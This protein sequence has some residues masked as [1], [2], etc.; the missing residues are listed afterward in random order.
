[1]I[2]VKLAAVA[3]DCG[4]RFHRRA[5]TAVTD[6]AVRGLETDTRR[7][8]EGEVFAAIK[9]E[10][11]DGA[12]LVAQL[13]DV[14]ASA[15]AASSKAPEGDRA[16]YASIA[17]GSRLTAIDASPVLGG[18]ASCGTADPAAA[19]SSAANGD[20][21]R[22]AEAARQWLQTDAAQLAPAQRSRQ[23]ARIE[24]VA[25]LQSSMLAAGAPDGRSGPA[26]PPA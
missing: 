2:P 20:S 13:Q 6:E 16:S 24:S 15:L 19:G 11:V 8:S 12:S 7:L 22:V 23:T 10:R 4:G 17:L 26:A 9:G 18:R 1:M 5:G 21:V 14:S 25:R 3:E